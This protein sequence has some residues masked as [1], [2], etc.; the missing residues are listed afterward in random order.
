M[1][2]YYEWVDLYYGYDIYWNK[3]ELCYAAFYEDQLFVEGKEI[4]KIEYNVD[5]T[6]SNL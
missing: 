2:A 5:E 1:E 3:K 6:D 4:N